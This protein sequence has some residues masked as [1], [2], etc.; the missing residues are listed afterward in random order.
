MILISVSIGLSQQAVSTYL[1]VNNVKALFWNNGVNFWDHQGA[2]KYYVPKNSTQTSMFSQTLWIGGYDS[3]RNLKLAGDRYTGN[4]NDFFPGPFSNIYDTVYDTKWNKIWKI[5][6]Q[7]VDQFITWYYNPSAFPNYQIPNE[8]LDW[9]AHGN[10]ARGQSQN[11]APFYDNNKDGIYNPNNGDFPL[12]KGDMAIWYIINDDRNPHTETGGAKIG[13]EIQLMAYAYSCNNAYDN[14][15]FMEY[16]ITK[17][18]PGK[19]DSTRIA[20]FSD[21]DLGYAQDDYIGCD[22]NRGAYY[23]YN[24]NLIDGSGTPNSYGA[25]PPAQAVVVL[26]GTLME[27][28][29]QDN[30]KLDINGSQ[31]CDESINGLNFGDGISDNEYSGLY[32]FISINNAN[33]VLGDPNSAIQYYNYMNLFWKDSIKINYGGD[34]HTNGAYGPNCRYMYPGL[35]DPCN[36]GLNGQAPNGSQNWTEETAGNMAGERRGLGIL[37]PTTLM[38]N[39]P[40]KIEIALVWAR[41]TVQKSVPALLS[42]IDTVRYYYESGTHPCGGTFLSMS[43][44]IAISK[45]I[46]LYP[47]P[48]DDILK[49]DLKRNCIAEYS[50]YD[51]SG[52]LIINGS[53]RVINEFDIQIQ[54]LHPGIYFI[55]INTEDHIYTKKFI[56]K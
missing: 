42:A 40:Q 12:F 3:L 15:I 16:T 53:A 52:K 36:Y 38:Q 48:A 26:K 10:P 20:F 9:P 35:S 19:L 28:D 18:T 2:S 27:A 13:I 6:R 4:G 44:E 34:G 29:M 32:G 23:C 50:I 43:K 7:T 22:V 37:R 14:T 11:L 33:S 54:S 55:K 5:E 1:D 51:I 30:P 41:D 25:N 49:I 17:K 31:L 47:N 24:G 45:P 46:S 56:K 21:I 8:I 39:I